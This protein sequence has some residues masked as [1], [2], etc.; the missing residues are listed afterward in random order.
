MGAQPS[1]VRSRVQN[2][3]EGPETEDAQERAQL[4][5]D[6]RTAEEEEIQQMLLGSD[7]FLF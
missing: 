3:V 2:K 7:D 6:E 4:I 1:N 5:E